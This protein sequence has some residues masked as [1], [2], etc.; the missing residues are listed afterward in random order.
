MSSSSSGPA[1]VLIAYV[2]AGAGHRRA[3]EALMQAVR[4]CL[5]DVQVECHD[6]LT[7]AP[8]WFRHG[9][10]WTYLF[11]VRHAPWVW[12]WSYGLL[13]R[14]PAYR[15]VQP[16]RRWWN[17]LVVRRFVE[18]LKAEPPDVIAVTH[19]LPADVCSA[20]KAA[21]WLRSRLV[22]VVT[23]YHP[24]R[25]WISTQ[26][27][28]VVASVPESLRQLRHRGL[29]PSRT[30]MLGIPVGEAFG[31]PVDAVAVRA[32]LQLEAGR[33][34]VLVTSGG[35]TVGQFERVVEG[36]LA[37]EA[38]RPGRLQLL[39]ICGQDAAAQRRLNLRAQASAMP[40]R[41]F[42][43][44]DYMADLM[45]ASD[46][47]VSKAGGLTISEALARGKPLVLYHI[48]P[49]QERMNA[50]YVSGHGAAVIAPHPPDVA[51]AVRRILDD[52]AYAAA[53]HRSAQ[54]LSRPRAAQEIVTRAI[55]PLL[56][57]HGQ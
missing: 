7:D 39:V 4:A 45:A 12:K 33:L 26:P 53:L 21:G 17:L 44:I 37:L 50:E 11:L 40:M 20:G 30:L 24:H 49:G 19:F 23:D 48:I 41:V 47:V 46:V 55:A 36:L 51:E 43:F 56:N 6:V 31:Q 54:A 57:S 1:R 28:I 3:A 18:R 35:T 42:G 34:T 27:D 13:D 52:P 8:G 5:P 29:D 14:E 32:R 38:S 9:Y 25:F 10:E 15:A 16:L 2:T 22:V